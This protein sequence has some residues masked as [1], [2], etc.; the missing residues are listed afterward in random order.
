MPAANLTILL[1]N[2]TRD[3]E[4]RYTPKGTACAE[5]GLAINRKFR[6][7]SGELREEVT[8]VDV[9]FWGKQAET[10][11]SYVTKGQPIYIEG[12]L[13]T[14]TWEDKQTGQKR[15]KLRVVAEKF[16]FLSSGSG[17]KTTA[18]ASTADAGPPGYAPEHF[19]EEDG[20]PF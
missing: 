17:K 3:P 18:P 13:A 8:F 4:L 7:E 9:T 2:A 10:I 14:D 5:I 11:N 20:I 15:S 1:G 6:T 12:R 16:Q 19:H